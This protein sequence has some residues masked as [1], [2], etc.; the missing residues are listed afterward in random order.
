MHTSALS[1]E[2][3]FRVINMIKEIN[4]NFNNYFSFEIRE[5]KLKFSL[6]RRVMLTCLIVCFFDTAYGQGM[7]RCIFRCC[8]CC[9]C[10]SKPCMD[11][12]HELRVSMLLLQNFGII[13]LITFVMLHLYLNSKV[14][15]RLT[16]SNLLFLYFVLLYSAVIPF[17]CKG[18][19]KMPLLL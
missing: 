19:L 17:L 2:K 13:S 15:L 9:C 8:C 14:A 16:C 6:K 5:L 10:F 3:N 12:A 18:A 11:S 7:E 4:S 1:V